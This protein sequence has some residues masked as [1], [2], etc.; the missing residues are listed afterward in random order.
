MKKC[1]D[2]TPRHQTSEGGG[3]GEEC[4]VEEFEISG[5]QLATHA[6][7]VIRLFAFDWR[8]LWKGLPSA[9]IGGPSSE[10]Q[11][12]AEHHTRLKFI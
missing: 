5:L 12:E 10:S 4:Q 1:R 6:R 11:R 7:C 9:V 3:E 2:S 8:P